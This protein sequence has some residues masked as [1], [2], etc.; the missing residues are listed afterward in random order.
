MVFTRQEWQ[1][2]YNKEHR[3]K[4]NDYYREYYKQHRLEHIKRVQDWR[5]RNPEKTK[6]YRDNIYSNPKKRQ[7]A[8]DYQTEW[9]KNNKD[10]IKEYSK[11][12]NERKKSKK[13]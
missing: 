9:R 1:R 10:K 2:R 11:K 7:A 13:L 8:L 6:Q 4:I 5:K 3:E 12:Y